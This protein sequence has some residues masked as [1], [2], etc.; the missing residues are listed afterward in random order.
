MKL[1]TIT[2]PYRKK[3]KKGKDKKQQKK[4]HKIT[5]TGNNNKT[6]KQNLS[7]QNHFSGSLHLFSDGL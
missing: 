7:T 4:K 2:I 6:P 1:K 5:R 3:E